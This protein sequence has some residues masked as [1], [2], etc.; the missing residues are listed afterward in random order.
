MVAVV[1][2]SD[3]TDAI[4]LLDESLTTP[5]L[6]NRGRNNVGDFRK[7]FL[8]SV[9][10]KNGAPFAWRSGTVSP[11]AF[12]NGVPQDSLV[13]QTGG[14]GGAQS[15]TLKAHRSLVVR[16]QGPYLWSQEADLVINAPAADGSNPRI[17][18]LCEMAYDKGAVG[19]DAQHGPKYIWVTGDP[20]G[21]PTIPALPAAVS[22]AYILAR[23]TRA[24]NDNT[25]ATA[26]ITN[27]QK[28]VSLH[29]G[30]RQ[31]MPGDALG[32]AGLYHGELRGRLPGAGIAA[33]MNNLRDL[34]EQWSNVDGLWHGTKNLAAVEPS[35]SFSGNIASGATQTIATLSIPDLGSPYAFTCS[36]SVEYIGSNAG[37]LVGLSMTVD[38]ATWGANEIAFGLANMQNLPGATQWVGALP[39][40]GA[41]PIP[42]GLTRTVRVLARNFNAAGGMNVQAATLRSG[43]EIVPL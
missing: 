13:L 17:D 29:G 30:I 7:E 37:A 5:G 25:I 33:A 9:F 27:V 12:T 38:S 26:D 4:P 1:V 21:S 2:Q 22:D 18:L 43:I 10:T 32:D 42:A 11:G 14:G 35:Q 31:L 19:S 40:P 23:V 34:V 6:Y 28:S 39:R 3:A 20:A 8:G 15:V 16:S 24:T 41:L 36:A